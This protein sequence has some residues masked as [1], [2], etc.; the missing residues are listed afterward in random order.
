MASRTI[1]LFPLQ[2]VVF[3]RTQLPL[4]IFEERYKEMVGNAI[5]EQP[6][7]RALKESWIA[8]A[9]LDAFPRQP[10]PADSELWS[11][12]NVI[13][14][15]RIGGIPA[16]KWAQLLPI[17]IDNLN[18]AIRPAT[19][20]AAFSHPWMPDKPNNGFMLRA[21][22]KLVGTIGAIYSEQVFGG[23]RRN[24]LNLT[25]LVV[26]EKYLELAVRQLH[27]TFELDQPAAAA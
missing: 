23:E 11:L 5:S 27:N 16:Q 12:S 3:P 1:P 21:D 18:R 17:F 25:S 22:G 10:L 4:H 24:F 6:L 14:S 26:D 13:I 2:V 8:G 9:A 20:K 7:V 15:P 19:W